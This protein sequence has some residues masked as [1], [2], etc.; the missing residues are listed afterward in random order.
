MLVRIADVGQ[1]VIDTTSCLFFALLGIRSV[2]SELLQV[3]LGK[4][5]S[6]THADKEQGL[7]FYAALPNAWCPQATRKENYSASGVFLT[8]L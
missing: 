2:L 7:V 8:K 1:R 3:E 4:R 6:H 5:N